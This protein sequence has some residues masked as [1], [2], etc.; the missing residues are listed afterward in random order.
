MDETLGVRVVDIRKAERRYDE[1]IFEGIQARLEAEQVEPFWQEVERLFYVWDSKS[2]GGVLL[3]P[4]EKLLIANEH[5][6]S[7]DSI[8]TVSQSTG[9]SVGFSRDVRHILIS[10]A[11]V[12]GSTLGLFAGNEIDLRVSP[13]LAKYY[14]KLSEYENERLQFVEV[15]EDREISATLARLPHI[16]KLLRTYANYYTILPLLEE[17]GMFEDLEVVGD[18]NKEVRNFMSGQRNFGIRKL[19][20]KVLFVPW[21]KNR[22]GVDPDVDYNALLASGLVV[23]METELPV[24]V[25]E[26]K[27]KRLRSA[28]N[29]YELVFR[30]EREREQRPGCIQE[31]AYIQDPLQEFREIPVV[32]Q[33]LVEI[34]ERFCN[35]AS[36]S[37]LTRSLFGDYGYRPSQDM[38]TSNGLSFLEVVLTGRHKKFDETS[39]G[40]VFSRNI[41]EQVRELFGLFERKRRSA[42]KV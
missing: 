4:R 17:S 1:E 11:I 23:L 21:V 10:A 35:G 29:Y 28:K 20:Q 14:E 9:V 22:A 37:E 40:K 18:Y 8:E 26:H 32:P 3:S 13:E 38:V 7:S 42:M 16:E 2:R 25:D 19:A 30:K 41:P 39:I 31:A 36:I 34:V 12:A 27:K 6:L 33:V 5:M 15:L 24:D